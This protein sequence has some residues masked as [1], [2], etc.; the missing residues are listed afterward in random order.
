MRAADLI[1]VCIGQAD[2][3]HLARR[4]DLGERADHIVVLDVRIRSVMLPQRDLLDTEPAQ[5]VVDRADEVLRRAVGVP[6]AS[7]V[8]TCPPFVARKT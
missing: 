6:A 2:H 1:G 8:R 3:P 4:V 7:S 5:A